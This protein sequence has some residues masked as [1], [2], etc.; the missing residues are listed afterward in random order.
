MKVFKEHEKVLL[1]LFTK[2]A[3]MT[4]FHQPLSRSFNKISETFQMQIE[5]VDNF[6]KNIALLLN[7]F[8][9]VN[10][11]HMHLVDLIRQN[12]SNSDEL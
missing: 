2:D 1:D 7:S 3:I 10:K 5:M 8:P 4:N 6:D 12:I 11:K 9:K